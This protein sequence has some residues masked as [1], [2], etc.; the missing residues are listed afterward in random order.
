MNKEWSELNKKMQL[1]LKKKD[2]FEDGIASLLL[3][4]SKLMEQLLVL[5]RELAVGELCAV[6]YKNADGYHSKTIAYSLWHIF[7]I[8]DILANTLIS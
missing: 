5:R 1:L 4:R 8:E 6:A 2:S 7:R 3:L